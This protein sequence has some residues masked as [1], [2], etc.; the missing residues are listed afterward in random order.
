MASERETVRAAAEPLCRVSGA[1]ADPQFARPP[2]TVRAQWL[3]P[4]SSGGYRLVFVR[5]ATGLKEAYLAEA[6]LALYCSEGYEEELRRIVVYYLRKT[7]TRGDRLDPDALFVQ[8]DVTRRARLYLSAARRDIDTL[9]TALEQDPSLSS[10]HDQICSRPE[11]CAVC[12]EEVRPLAADHV[13]TLH[14]GGDFARALFAQ[15]VTSILD[16]HPTELAHDRQRIQQRALR[17]G[18]PQI[19]CATL[20]AF[21]ESLRYPLRYLDFEAT[22]EPLPAYPGLRPW[23]HVPF[24]YSIHVQPGPG[25]PLEHHE[26]MCSARND[27]RETL[28]RNLIADLGPDGSIVV[29][30]AAFER[31]VMNRLGDWFADYRDALSAAVARIVDLLTPFNEFAYYQA[32]QRGRVSLK[33]VLPAL[34]G[35]NYD[36]LPVRDGLTA[37]MAFRF[38]GEHPDLSEDQRASI[39]TELSEYCAMD[40]M[41]MVLILR[42]LR[43]VCR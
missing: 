38:L 9:L 20:T 34:T 43:E 31:G 10:Y 32:E 24:L 42:R 16:L 30:S 2:F 19:D 39:R 33:R 17:S 29:Y 15:G 12:S 5:E 13:L 36:S 21:L 18:E 8:A 27:D 3:L 11:S 41:A 6:A 40:T 23:E 1:V 28:A 14:R 4:E 22:N 26:F 7:Y 35:A 25:A 37:N